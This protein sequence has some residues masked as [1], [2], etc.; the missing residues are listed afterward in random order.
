MPGEKLGRDVQ[1]TW[2]LGAGRGG[3]S[4]DAALGLAMGGAG[5][6]GFRSLCPVRF[7]SASMLPIDSFHYPDFKSGPPFSYTSGSSIHL[8]RIEPDIMSEELL[9]ISRRTGLTPQHKRHREHQ[10]F[11]L[12]PGLFNQGC[13]CW[14]RFAP[15]QYTL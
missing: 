13:S 3:G 15:Q 11:G 5:R 7:Q 2:G 12:P 8:G 4:G 14:L 9:Q 10:P 6:Q 1:E